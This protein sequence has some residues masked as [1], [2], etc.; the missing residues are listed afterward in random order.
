M[1]RPRTN[2]AF[3]AALNPVQR[4]LA[5]GRPRLRATG[6]GTS[7]EGAPSGSDGDDPD[8]RAT[9][10]ADAIQ[11]GGRPRRGFCASRRSSATMHSSTRSRCAF[12]FSRITDISMIA[13]AGKRRRHPA[14]GIQSNNA[15]KH[16]A[17]LKIS[18]EVNQRER[19]E[20]RSFGR[21]R[22]AKALLQVFLQ[23]K[24]SSVA[25]FS[26]E[27]PSSTIRGMSASLSAKTASS[28]DSTSRAARRETAGISPNCPDCRRLSERFERLEDEYSVASRA[29]SMPGAPESGEEHIRLEA[30]A[31]EAR[32][33]TRKA[34]LE[35]QRHWGIHRKTAMMA[36]ATI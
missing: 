17:F 30:V 13:I 32:Q 26:P 31:L 20:F 35:L 6:C 36:R 19:A 23:G 22:Q 33:N 5:G 16:S 11:F 25:G 14:T 34:L 3:S 9:L 28:A 1:G 7:P 8:S 10:R 18:A 4:C 2:P 27:A 24:F 12:K 21:R 29:V 15:T